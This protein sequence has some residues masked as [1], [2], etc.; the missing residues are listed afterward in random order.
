M[1]HLLLLCVL[2]LSTHAFSLAPDEPS[3][4]TTHTETE[5]DPYAVEEQEVIEFEA[6]SNDDNPEEAEEAELIEGSIGEEPLAE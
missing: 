5:E 1:K 2:I 3:E 4:V 6:P